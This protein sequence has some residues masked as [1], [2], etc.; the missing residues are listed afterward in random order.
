M[1]KSIEQLAELFLK[2]P[3]IGPRQ[4][5]RF[6]YHLLRA[7]SEYRRDL[8]KKINELGGAIAQCSEC[9]RYYDDDRNVDGVCSI[10][11]NTTRDASLLMVVEKDAD[12][13]AIERSSTY[14][15]YY[16][17]LGG[18]V[19]VATDDAKD[20]VRGAVLEELVQK[21]GKED[22]KE[23]IIATSATPDGEYTGRL[24]AS[25]LSPVVQGTG[26]SVSV[27]GRGLSTGTELEYSD[28][29]TL[30]SALE[31]RKQNT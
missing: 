21:R 5:K 9:H 27:L 19:S 4:A 16:F 3:G 12:L 7:P 17:V 29:D 6:V 24:I 14:Q 2:F 30:K 25:L 8:A 15:G 11:S 28:R 23:V 31:N 22:L 18:T 10:C 1:N 26:V 20:A 13:D